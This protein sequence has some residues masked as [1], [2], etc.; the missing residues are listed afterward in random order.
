MKINLKIGSQEFVIDNNY[1]S[2]E[3]FELEIK[4]FIEESTETKCEFNLIKKDIISLS[5]VKIF[6]KQS[7]LIKTYD[8]SINIDSYESLLI[9][10]TFI[11]KTF[12]KNREKICLTIDN[13]EM[14]I[15]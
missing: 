12:C 14:E 2:E 5:K 6:D 3:D 13:M 1:L 10:K 4:D 11:L 15:N 7:K 9:L 8:T